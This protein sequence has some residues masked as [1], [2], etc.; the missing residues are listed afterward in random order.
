MPCLNKAEDHRRA[1]PAAQSIR[2]KEPGWTEGSAT[3]M[4]PE[5]PIKPA[6]QRRRRRGQRAYPYIMT[7]VRRISHPST[8]HRTGHRAA[9]RGRGNSLHRSETA[10]RRHPRLWI[11]TPRRVKEDYQSPRRKV[12]RREG[13]G[14]RRA[15]AELIAPQPCDPCSR[16]R[17]PA[18]G[19]C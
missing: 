9:R 3:Q 11:W 16:A 7:A 19:Q 4:E 1:S 17:F 12:G 14:G 13:E 8:S 18:G 6:P 15:R 5:S 10:D 2:R